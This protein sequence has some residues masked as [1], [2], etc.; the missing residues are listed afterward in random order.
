MAGL[1][2]EGETIASRDVVP[3]NCMRKC[4]EKLSHTISRLADSP[5]IPVARLWLQK[6][7]ASHH[8]FAASSILNLIA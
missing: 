3:V 6:E 2:A 1:C 4:V 5:R 8:L 7:P